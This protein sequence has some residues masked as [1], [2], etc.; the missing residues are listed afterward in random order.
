V[1]TDLQTPCTIVVRPE[2]VCLLE[3]ECLST[4]RDENAP[5]EEVDFDEIDDMPG[6]EALTLFVQNIVVYIAGFVGRSVARK[7]KC[8]SCV[9]ALMSNEAQPAATSEE[10]ILINEK[11]NGGLFH[12]STDLIEVCRLTEIEIRR[13]TAQGI[14]S[15]KRSTVVAS[16]VRQSVKSV[17][18]ADL[19]TD[20]DHPPW[21]DHVIDLIKSISEEY[22]K[23]R[24]HHM[25]REATLA[26]CPVSIRSKCTKVV[27]FSGN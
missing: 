24:F 13:A 27:H 7:S 21:S 22:V 5:L 14:A 18:F 15:V 3:P 2:P 1:E 26:A 23:I 16:A 19:R 20:K 8:P 25:S 9:L 17:I 4:I 6:T 10:Y 12:P 11:D